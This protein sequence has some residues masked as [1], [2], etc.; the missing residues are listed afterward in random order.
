MSGTLVFIWFIV[1][2]GV[3]I[4]GESIYTA[5]PELGVIP[6]IS[7]FLCSFHMRCNLGEFGSAYFDLNLKRC[8]VC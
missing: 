6:I 7:L 8:G 2:E 3:T 5:V 1:T 4:L